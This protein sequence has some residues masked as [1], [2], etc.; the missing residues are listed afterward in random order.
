VFE[1]QVQRLRRA[2]IFLDVSL[3][4][5]ALLA[6]YYLR[7]AVVGE[8]ASLPAHLA[9]LLVIAPLWVFLLT[10]FKGYRSPRGAAVLDLSWNVARAVSSGLAVLLT[11]LFFLKLQYVSR[12]IVLVFGG[13]DVLALIGVRLVI[14]W[15]YRRSLGRGQNFQNVLVIGSGN[16]AR[17]LGETIVRTSEWGIHIV[18]YLDTDPARVGRSMPGSNVLGTV[19]EITSVLK[20]HVI[21]EVIVAVPR[22]MIGIAEKVVRACHEEGVKVRFMADLFDLSVARVTLDAVGGIPLLTMEPVAHD[23]WQLLVK[24]VLDLAAGLLVLPPLLPLM[25]VIALAIRL[26]S[27]GPVLFIQD[28]V[29]LNKRR[30]RMFKFRTMFEGSERLQAELEPLNQAKGPIFKIFDDPRVTRVGRFLRRTSLDELP[31]L[32]NVIRGEM[33]LVGPRPMSVRD[34]NL[35]DRGI[36]RKRFS[37][38]PGMTGLWQISGRSTVSFSEWLELDLWYIEHWSLALD[39]RILFRTIPAVLRQKGAA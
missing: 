17:H 12:V 6:A 18:G 28:R 3:T 11:L 19:D 14:L 21:D 2:T 5:L 9:L 4:A 26:D 34:V 30:F 37:V 16:R 31:Q 10:L 15:D 23:E 8:F 25:A 27:R 36:Q 29:G 33:S 24:R 39:L 38:K 20:D 7:A 35:F 32:F 1:Q 13:L 22:G